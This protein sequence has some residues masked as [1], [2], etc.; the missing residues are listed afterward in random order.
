MKKSTAVK[1]RAKP[2]AGDLNGLGIAG[3]KLAPKKK[4]VV[5]SRSRLSAASGAK[6]KAPAAKAVPKL[7]PPKSKVAKKAKP[8]APEKPNAEAAVE[9]TP[10]ELALKEVEIVKQK[11]AAA[12]VQ[13]E[14]NGEV[15]IRYNHYKTPFPIQDGKLAA[16][17]IDDKFCISFAF[18]DSRLHLSTQ[19][20]P[21]WGTEDPMEKEDP[22]GTFVQLKTTNEYWV[23]VEEDAEAAAASELKQ[24]E[25]IKRAENERKEAEK[26]KCSLVKEKMEGCSCIEGNPCIDKYGCKDWKN[27]LEVAKKHGWKGF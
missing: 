14:T 5:P 23:M 21:E 20:N 18:P 25:F 12:L 3:K 26:E 11:E 4:G 8:K 7:R 24:Q 9:L 22:V 16:S 17:V 6:T 15:I 1:P 10:E 27:R 2:A 19:A 13:A